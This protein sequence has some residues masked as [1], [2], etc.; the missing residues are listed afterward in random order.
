LKGQNMSGILSLIAENK[1]HN[2]ASK[3]EWD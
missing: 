2:V 1:T 3:F